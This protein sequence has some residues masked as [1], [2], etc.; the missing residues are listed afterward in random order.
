MLVKLETT[1]FL[2]YA[3]MEDE[4]EKWEILMLLHSLIGLEKG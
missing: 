3:K 1:K 4:K 2:I